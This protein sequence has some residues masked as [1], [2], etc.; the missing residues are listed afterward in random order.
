[1]MKT[2]DPEVS[3]NE[4]AGY[5]QHS[6]D[7]LTTGSTRNRTDTYDPE[8]ITTLQQVEIVVDWKIARREAQKVTNTQF[9]QYLMTNMVA[10]RHNRASPSVA[11]K[12]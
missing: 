11:S 9:F 4:C 5:A 1:M 6:T 3:Y 7:L 10:L 2:T 8:P 12:T